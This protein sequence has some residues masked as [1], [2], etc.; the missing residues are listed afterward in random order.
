MSG[1][2]RHAHLAKIFC[3]LI[4]ADRGSLLSECRVEI[5]HRLE[6]DLHQVAVVLNVMHLITGKCFGIVYLDQDVPAPAGSVSLEVTHA[7]LDPAI[8]AALCERLKCA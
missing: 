7:P 3:S 2:T 6:R 4:G 5:E 1:T 8:V